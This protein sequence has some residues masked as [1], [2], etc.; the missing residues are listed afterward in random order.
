[1]LICPRV[2]LKF[3]WSPD[4]VPREPDPSIFLRPPHVIPA[5]PTTTSVVRCS[6]R[7][8]PGKIK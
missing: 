7:L 3:P 5:S 1:M 4:L 2:R 6:H 8:D